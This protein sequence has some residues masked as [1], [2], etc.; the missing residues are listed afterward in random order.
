M[1]CFHIRYDC[2]VPC[3]SMVWTLWRTIRI[4]YTLIINWTGQRTPKPSTRRPRAVS[5]FWDGWSLSTSA[6]E[7][8]DG[9]RYPLRCCVLGQQAE[10][11]NR[12][13][14][15]SG[16]C[17]VCGIVGVELD[18]L[19][20]VSERRMLSKYMSSWT[21]SPTPWCVVLNTGGHS[22]WDWLHQHAPSSMAGNHSCTWPSNCR[23]SLSDT[24]RE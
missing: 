13:K 18:F 3:L 5:I 11:D 14:L 24:W 1:E 8:F 10:G 22:K 7:S 4:G 19:T 23:T 16:L 9:Q 6:N 2:F 21:K 17:G 12:L 15:S 20:A